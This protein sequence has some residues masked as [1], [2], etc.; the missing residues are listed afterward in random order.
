MVIL[1]VL[2]TVFTVVGMIIVIKG[3]RMSKRGDFEA[4]KMFS[5]GFLAMAGGDV[6]SA[7]RNGITNPDPIDLILAAAFFYFAYDEWKK[8]I[9]R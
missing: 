6:M 5:Y 3:Y 4:Y 7:F 2:G 9:G 8:Y 1:N